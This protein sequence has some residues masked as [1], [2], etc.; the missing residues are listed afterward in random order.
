MALI[1]YFLMALALAL[2]LL[3]LLLLIGIPEYTKPK[4]SAKK[5]PLL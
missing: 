2:A 3:L 1:N 4:K 5:T